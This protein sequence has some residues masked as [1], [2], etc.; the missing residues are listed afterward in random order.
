MYLS[1]S[2]RSHEKHNW[3]LFQSHLKN[4]FVPNRRAQKILQPKVPRFIFPQTRHCFCRKSVHL[5]M[6]H[7]KQGWKP[8]PHLLITGFQ[9]GKLTVIFRAVHNRTH[10]KN[11]SKRKIWQCRLVH[12]N[13]CWTSSN[14]INN[15]TF[16]RVKK[17]R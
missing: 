1:D 5:G 11:V 17:N 13:P 9:Y 10:L 4:L 6:L 2:L 16:T 7:W 14:K 3:G 8:S 12:F 15:G